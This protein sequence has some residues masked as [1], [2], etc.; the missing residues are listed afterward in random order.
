MFSV[1]RKFRKSAAIIMAMIIVPGLIQASTIKLEWDANTE[2]DLQGYKIY[3]GTSSTQYT[4]TLTLGKV[5]Q[6]TITD[7]DAGATYYICLTAFDQ[8]F[9]ESH[10]SNE[11]MVVSQDNDPPE[12]VT[13]ACELGDMVK[14]VFNEIVEKISSE[15]TSNYG[16]DNGIVVTLAKRQADKKTILL[17]TNQHPN[18]NYTL[19]I[20]SIRDSAAVPNVMSQGVQRNYSWSGNDETAPE[21]I[22]VKLLNYDLLK[23]TFSEPVDENAAVDLSN[24]ALSSGISISGATIDETFRIVYLSTSEHS[25]GGSYSVTVN[26]I[27]DDVGNRIRA[28]TIKIYSRQSD[29]IVPPTLTAIHNAAANSLAIQFS[30]KLDRSSAENVSNYII[31]GS[32]TVTNASLNAAGDIVTLTTSTHSGGAYTVTVSDV[33]DLATPPNKIV[34]AELAYSYFPPDVTAPELQTVNIT[35][36]N[37]LKLAFNESVS[38]VT[39]ENKANYAITPAVQIVDVTLDISEKIVILETADHPQGDYRITVHSIQDKAA[40]PNTITAG[41]YL[42]YNFT[43]PDTKRPVLTGI[44]MH[45][46]DLVELIFDESLERTSA[47]TID[48]YQISNGITVSN[49]A[50]VGDNYDRVYLN[51]NSHQNNGTY[52]ITISNVTD[53]AASPNVIN[54]NTIFTYTYTANDDVAPSIV[55]VEQLG[56]KVIK[57][58]FSEAVNAAQAVD[59]N[60]YSFTPSLNVFSASLDATGKVVF[61]TTAL[62]Q[63]GTSYVITVSGI[64]DL[65]TNPNTISLGNSFTYTTES[66]DASAPI[67]TGAE[68][69]GNQI[70][71]IIFNEPVDAVSAQNTNNYSIDNSV[72]IIKAKLSTSQMMVFLETSPQQRGTYTVTISNIKDQAANANIISTG[73]TVQYTFIPADDQK[74]L[75]IDAAFININTIELLFNE[76]LHR[77]SAENSINYTIDNNISVTRATLNYEGTKVTLQTSTHYPGTFTVNVDNVKDG[78]AA[79]NT[80]LPNTSKTYEYTIQDIVP[81]RIVSAVPRD[82]THLW[83]TFNEPMDPVTASEKGHYTISEGIEVKSAVLIAT[84]ETTDKDKSTVMIPQAQVQLETS[85]H[86]AGQFLLTVNG[87]CDASDAKNAITDYQQVQ[88]IWSPVDTTDPALVRASLIGTNNLKLQFSEALNGETAR[89]KSN[90]SIQPYVEIEN[91]V[92]DAELNIVWLSTKV[93]AKDD[94]TVTAINV[95]DRAFKANT[96]GVDNRASYSYQPPDTVAPGIAI[97]ELHSSPQMVYVTFDEPLARDEAENIANYSISNGIKIIRADLNAALTTVM[98]ETSTHQINVNYEIRI[99]NMRDRAPTPNVL[100]TPLS[101]IYKFTPPDNT[102]PE[103]LNVK[104][105]GSNQLEFLFSEAVNKSDAENPANYQFNYNVDIISL[106]LDNKNM[107]RLTMETADH[108]VGINYQVCALNIHDLAAIPNTIK[109]NDWH[110]YKRP[111]T[112]GSA[113]QTAPVVMRVELIS[114]TQVDVIFSEPVDS[115]TAKIAANYSISNGVKV[116]KAAIAQQLSRVHLTTSTHSDGQSYAIQVHNIKDLATSPNFISSDSPAN[117]Y[118]IQA[119]VSF[120]RL[121]KLNYEMIGFKQNNLCYTDRDYSF[122]LIPTCLEGS[123]QIQTSND[124]KADTS[125]YFLSFEI[126]GDATIFV[127]YDTRIGSIPAWLQSWNQTGEQVLNS[128]KSGYNVYSKDVGNGLVTLGGNRGGLDD[129]M[130]M[131]FARPHISASMVISSLTRTGYNINRLSVGDRYYIDRDY[132][133]ANIPA[134]MED[135]FWISTA[136]DDKANDSEDFL[137]FDLLTSSTVY[138][139]YDEKAGS[140]PAWMDKW[141]LMEDQIVDSRG[142]KFKVYAKSYA[143]GEVVL[144]GNSATL[145]DNMYLVLVKPDDIGGQNGNSKGPAT[146]NLGQNYPNPFNPVTTIRFEVHKAG[147]VKLSIINIMGQRV[148]TLIDEDVSGGSVKEVEWDGTDLYGTKVASGVYFYRIQQGQFAKTRRMILLR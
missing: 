56:A 22:E 124:D 54:Y 115:M 67:I 71:E 126:K 4:T 27:H 122:N 12:V 120:S 144:G 94:Y 134:F 102:P 84:S 1:F 40:N 117:K 20:S 24:Y 125:E 53:R 26:N 10:Y 11:I 15:L 132:T 88:Y 136:N 108:L 86:P 130:Y 17:H 16:I 50:L 78:S 74:P 68:S 135:I 5:T 28:N 64:Q 13:V 100:R 30:E 39:A 89:N 59:I 9:N 14:V 48:N 98:I 73:S 131:V 34:S 41:S 49:A 55:T 33:Y 128:R 145:D 37:L 6:Y 82:N 81:P 148:R 141:L 83:V 75:L 105:Q 87:A 147:H 8:N 142:V 138:I 18:G 44:E 36:K 111:L 90:Y 114:A 21:I 32:V 42:T 101:R 45:G 137:K 52:T 62:H 7:L 76:P 80:I 109:P 77:V 2:N 112:G 58:I 51:T 63:Q 46:N 93:H 70:V 123:V 60:N 133:L 103:L 99:S 97:V 85:E 19:T 72:N 23:I 47:E 121:N 95:K 113:D 38:R 91:A 92:L 106:T 25:P 140:I 129:N 143:S 31:S 66:V 127:A 65:A 116:Q 119:G 35:S 139:A 57:V 110:T 29:D 104:L 79:G 61:L 107:R 118:L 43:P 3:Y 69:H 146:F 96:I